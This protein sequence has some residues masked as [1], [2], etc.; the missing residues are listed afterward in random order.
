MVKRLRRD[1][2]DSSAERNRF[3]A[4]RERSGHS[5]SNAQGRPGAACAIDRGAHDSARI[6]GSLAHRPEVFKAGSESRY[7]IS[8]HSNRTRAPRL[9]PNKDALLS[10]IARKLALKLPNSGAKSSRHTFGQEFVDSNGGRPKAIARSPQPRTRATFDKVD[11]SLSG[12]RIVAS[13]R[14]EEAPLEC[15]LII[16]ARKN[17]VTKFSR[18]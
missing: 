5:L 17:S 12:N 4:K 11:H 7:A 3:N 10:R 18:T 8:R 2:G 1:R 14:L 9:D 13:A 16:D 15:F 6:P